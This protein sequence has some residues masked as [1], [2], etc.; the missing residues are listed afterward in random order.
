MLD[1]LFGTE[2]HYHLVVEVPCIIDHYVF[3]WTILAD[4]VFFYKPF[5]HILC[6][7]SI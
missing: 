2:L 3:W 5:H 4:Q 7:M 6:D 1:F